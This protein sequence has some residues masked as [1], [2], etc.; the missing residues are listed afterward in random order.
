MSQTNTLFKGIQYSTGWAKLRASSNMDSTFYSSRSGFQREMY[1]N[2]V[3]LGTIASCYRWA[4][5]R[6]LV[7]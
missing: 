5:W 1:V 6:L 7:H 3:T 4:R 2:D